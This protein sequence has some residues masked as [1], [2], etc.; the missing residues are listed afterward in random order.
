MG[1]FGFLR[2]GDLA[3]FGVFGVLG[4]GFCLVVVL[5]FW[6][7]FLVLVLGLP[8]LVF[9]VFCCLGFL[10]VF[11]WVCWVCWVGDFPGLGFGGF[12]LAFCIRCF[13]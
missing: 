9:W 4:V 2:R 12:C 7:C 13:S 6:V 10:L 11:G 8:N 1:A 5:V 3:D